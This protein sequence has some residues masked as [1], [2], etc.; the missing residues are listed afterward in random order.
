MPTVPNGRRLLGSG[1]GQIGARQKRPRRR[2]GGCGRRPDHLLARP[3]PSAY[4]ARPTRAQSPSIR[5]HVPTMEVSNA[6]IADDHSLVEPAFSQYPELSRPPRSGPLTAPCTAW[7][8]PHQLLLQ[9]FASMPYIV[10]LRLQDSAASIP[11][12][13]VSS[14]SNLKRVFSMVKREVH[15][16]RMLN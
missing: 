6:L 9:H 2:T 8:K 15:R 12:D 11:L 1:L 3:H 14:S 10:R 7:P 13:M 4:S 5:S 16:L